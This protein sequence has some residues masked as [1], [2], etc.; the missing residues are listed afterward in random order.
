MAGE[1]SFAGRRAVVTGAGG[2]IGG[3]VARALAAAGAD[4]LA[5]D[6]ASPGLSQ[7]GGEGLGVL[8][9]D[10]G[11]AEGRAE[12]VERASRVHY[13]VNCHGII[14]ARPLAEVTPDDWDRVDAVNGKGTFFVLQS[15]LDRIVD[16]GAIVNMASAAGKMG[17]TVE[18]AVYNCSKA[19]VIAMTKTF[20]YA[21]APRRVRVNCVCAGDIDTGMQDTAVRDIAA[22]RQLAEN[23]LVAG[24]LTDIPLGR[25]GEAEEVASVILFLL[26]DAASYMTGQA[27]NVTGG[28][29]TY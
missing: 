5:T 8:P 21:L 4:V 2:G 23:E 16:G 20:A 6:L 26:S 12:L 27:V 14:E 28:L 10:L 13:L 18:V 19:A 15:F 9:C 25:V 11:G 3:A 24:R 17:K 7:L 29:V 22:L 1:V